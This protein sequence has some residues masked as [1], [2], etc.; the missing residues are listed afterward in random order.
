M[1]DSE[2]SNSVRPTAD[3][4][5]R[6]KVAFKKQQAAAHRQKNSVCSASEIDL[7]PKSVKNGLHRTYLATKTPLQG[8][9]RSADR[10]ERDEVLGVKPKTHLLTTKVSVFR[11][12]EDEIDL[13]GL[14]LVNSD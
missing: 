1:K 5:L 12:F 7:I 3:L 14:N 9:R 13:S 6:L 4:P 2:D 10:E 8:N 11:K